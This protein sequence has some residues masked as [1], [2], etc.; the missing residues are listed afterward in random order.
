MVAGEASGDLHGSRLAIEIKRLRPDCILRGIGGPKMQEAGVQLLFTLRDFA[1][2]GFS[3]V[4]KHLPFIR[5]AFKR[6]N[7]LFLEDKPDLLIL[8]DYPGFNIRLAKMAKKRGITVLY[9]ISPQVWAWQPRRAHAM[10]R[11]VDRLVVVLPF[12]VKYYREK[13]GLRAH[14]VGHPLL[15]VVRS[16]KSRDT[17]C[18]QEG[19]DPQSPVLGLLPGS[20][21]QE[22]ARLLPIM[23]QAG[24]LL[25]RRIPHLQIAVGAVST[26]DDDLY[27]NLLRDAGGE[28]ALI[29]DQTYDLMDHARLL[30]VASGTATLESAII[31][32]PMIILYRISFISWL[33]ALL[34][35]KVRYIG[36]VN[37]V[38]GERIVPE[39]VQ[40]QVTAPRIA[41]E[42]YRLLKNSQ[43]RAQ[44]AEKLAQI[45]SKLGNRGASRRAAELALSLIDAGR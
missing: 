1:F 3:E 11:W 23:L 4:L 35:V 18:R 6:L 10:A 44:M 5:R 7:R 43:R 21:A 34:L 45:R 32:T 17:F 39:L 8:I 19:L 41:R 33:I 30:L 24:R 20:R 25:R 38:A 12:E 14:F 37:L 31:G 36:L 22:V 27:Q 13:I 16:Q 2:L 42:A 9:Y 40:Y 26:V 15:E 28:V 29:T